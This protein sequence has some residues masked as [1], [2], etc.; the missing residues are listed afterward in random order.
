VGNCRSAERRID[1]QATL[2]RACIRL[3]QPAIW[4][5]LAKFWLINLI[6]TALGFSLYLRWELFLCA[7][8]AAPSVGRLGYLGST[9]V[10]S[11]DVLMLAVLFHWRV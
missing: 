5:Q 11:F 6:N 2:L 1:A 7:A 8:E 3:T 4:F 10:I 9:F